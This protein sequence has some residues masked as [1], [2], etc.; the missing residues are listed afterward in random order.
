MIYL[1]MNEL[2]LTA[3]EREYIASMDFFD[4]DYAEYL[5]Q[6]RYRP[7]EQVHMKFDPQTREL[8]L[9]VTGLWHETILYEVPLLALISEA[10]FK[11]VDRDWNYDGQSQNAAD[12]C[13]TLLEN[14]CKFSEF[15]T[16]RRR[17]FKTHDTVMH[18]LKEASDKYKASTTEP[19]GVFTGTS[20]VYFAK[21]YGTPAIG[22]VGK[23]L[24]TSY[25]EAMDKLITWSTRVLYGY[26]SIGRCQAC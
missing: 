10:Y 3:E 19:K 7:E 13:K 21:K 23:L 25:H 1:D 11:F 14:G 8:E 18:A 4:K 6:F 22:T 17:D 16:R 24:W 26:F 15:G 12:K 2:A 5:F 9:K 20:N